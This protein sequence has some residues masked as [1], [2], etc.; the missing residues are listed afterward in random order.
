MLGAPIEGQ[1]NDVKTRQRQGARGSHRGG[2]NAGHTKYG[3]CK[4]LGHNKQT[5]PHLYAG[6]QPNS[7]DVGGEVGENT[8]RPEGVLEG[9]SIDVLQTS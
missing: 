6:P 8:V 7:T 3:N 1:Q 5:C 9:K 4:A 2:P